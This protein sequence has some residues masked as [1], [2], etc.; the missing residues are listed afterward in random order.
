[1]TQDDQSVTLRSL[2]LRPEKCCEGVAVKA[3]GDAAHAPLAQ[4]VVVIVREQHRVERRQLLEACRH[5]MKALGPREGD[6]RRSVP[7]H[8]IRE[9]TQAVR[10]DQ[11]RAV[12]EPGQPEPRARNRTKPG[13]ERALHRNDARRPAR[14]RP[15]EELAEHWQGGP[16]E[17]RPARRRVLEAAV[18]KLPGCPSALEPLTGETNHGCVGENVGPEPS[19]VKG[20]RQRGMAPAA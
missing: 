6:R 7:E 16:F 15:E 13:A 11:H 3:I 9:H 17:L 4:V 8:R 1:M 2:R 12:T 14:P 18:P 10:L 20:A 5:G 19:V